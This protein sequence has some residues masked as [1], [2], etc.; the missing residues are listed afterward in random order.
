MSLELG[1]DDAIGI[2]ARLAITLDLSHVQICPARVA[3]QTVSATGPWGLR[4]L[5]SRLPFRFRFQICKKITYILIRS[6]MRLYRGGDDARGLGLTNA[7]HLCIDEIDA[8]PFPG[9]ALDG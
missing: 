5:S 6:I 8:S 2:F 9:P 3:Q 4:A 1:T 7:V